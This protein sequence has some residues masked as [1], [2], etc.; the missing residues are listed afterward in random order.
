MIFDNFNTYLFYALKLTLQ[1]TTL[2]QCYKKQIAELEESSA[3]EIAKL[4]KELNFSIASLA[5]AGIAV[6]KDSINAH[7][8]PVQFVAIGSGQHSLDN[9]SALHDRP[10]AV[11]EANVTLLQREEGEV[12]IQNQMSID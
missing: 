5:R 7:Q 12:H 10:E 8:A 9:G 4:K 3:S 1:M 11:G 6:S 2:T